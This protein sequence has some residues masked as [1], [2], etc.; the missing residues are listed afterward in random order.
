MSEDKTNALYQPTEV[1][2]IR[3]AARHFNLPFTESQIARI[4]KA[5]LSLEDSAARLREGLHRNDEPA[6]GFRHPPEQ[7]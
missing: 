3:A 4:H 1:E 6:F 5:V 2:D 7:P